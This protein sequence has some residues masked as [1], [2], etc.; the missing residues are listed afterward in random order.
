MNETLTR[1]LVCDHTKF[2]PYLAVKDYFLSG[3]TFQL[4]QCAHC[5]FKFINPRPGSEEIGRYYQSDEYISHDAN[6]KDLISRIYKIA[7]NFSIKGK[8]NLVK[9]YTGSGTLLDYGCGTGE[10]LHYCKSNGFSVT[11]V[12]PND[13]AR[14]FGIEQNKITVNANLDMVVPPPGGFK[15]ITLWHV[16]EHIHALNETIEKLNSLL[17]NHGVLIIA[18]P[19]C[20]SPDAVKYQNF[21]AA[22]DVPRHLYHFT[23]GTINLLAAKHRFSVEKIVPQKLDAYY[24]SMLSEKYKNNKNNLVK[25]F[26][27]GFLSNIHAAMSKSG[28]SSQIFIMRRKMG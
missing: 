8:Y 9:K 16:L 11:G 25:A 3:E 1:C 14:T 6:K 12:E 17:G 19:N 26:L 18:V 28:Y 15:C 20:A 22:Y 13:K 10:F 23:A 21:W 5:G 27:T 2:E 24:V 4:Q 7:R